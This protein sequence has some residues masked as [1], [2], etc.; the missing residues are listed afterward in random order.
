MHCYKIN[1]ELGLESVCLLLGN[2]MKRLSIVSGCMIFVV[3]CKILQ[4]FCTLAH[5][6]FSSSADPMITYTHPAPNDLPIKNFG[7]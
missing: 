6:P 4:L 2:K 3:E 7:Y 5:G 1:V